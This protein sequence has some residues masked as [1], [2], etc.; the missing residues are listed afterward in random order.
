MTS[1]HLLIND[2][3]ISEFVNALDKDRVKVIE[4]NFKE[5]QTIIQDVLTSYNSDNSDFIPYYESM[6]DM[7][8]WL[9]ELEVK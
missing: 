4:E 2:E 9:K 3:Y 6:Q 1:L 8:I 5:N 7:S